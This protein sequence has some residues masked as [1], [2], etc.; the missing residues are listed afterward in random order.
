MSTT[1]RILTAAVLTF[2]IAF[3]GSASAKDEVHWGYTGAAGPEKWGDLK[4][5]FAACKTG[6]RQSPIDIKGA[7]AADLEPI[8]F[9]YKPAPLRI[10][11]NGHTIQVN[12]PAG[13]SISVGRTLY[14]LVQ[15]HFHRPSEE[16]VNG[17]ASDMVV[18]LVH[19]DKD[20]NLGVVGVLLQK[21]RE[22]GVLKALWSN[23][24]REKEKEVT[25]DKV[26]VDPAGLLPA[27][28]S[29]YT[30]PGSLTTPPCSEGVTWFLLKTPTQVSAAQIDRFAKLYKLNARPVQ[31]LNDRTLK[32]SK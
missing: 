18:H 21:G 20:G 27:D 4:P 6:K 8:T 13:S 7:V 26:T 3:P 15:F 16:K 12:Y 17:K 30:F 2:T 9:E 24:P 1:S 19:R 22:N 23:L 14:D 10:I 5:E 25:I 32:V 31:P 28:R 29:Y 11:D